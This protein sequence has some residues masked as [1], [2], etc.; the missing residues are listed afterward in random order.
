[1]TTKID[2]TVIPV[3]RICAYC[4]HFGFVTREPGD[5]TQGWAYCKHHKAHFKGQ[6]PDDKPAGKRTCPHWK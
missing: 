2:H 1:M 4:D 5:T 6:G 3:E